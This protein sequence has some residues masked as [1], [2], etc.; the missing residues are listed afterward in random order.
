[1]G[2]TLRPDA[3]Y[4]SQAEKNAISAEYDRMLATGVK[5]YHPT[6]GFTPSPAMTRAELTAA[7]NARVGA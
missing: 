7:E 6:P 3:G 4:M 2:V 5:G 1:M